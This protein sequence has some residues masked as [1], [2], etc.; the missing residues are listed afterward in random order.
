MQQ[1]ISMITLGVADAA[2]ARRFYEALGWSGDS[3]DGD[4]VIFQAGGMI[5]G[6]WGRDRL[7]VDSGVS[8]PGGWGGVTFAHYVNSVAEVDQ[9]LAAAEDA[10]AT[11]GRA[12]GPTS[13]GGY[14][15]VFLDIDGHPWEIG[16]NPG[17]VVA[18][19]GSFKPR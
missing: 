1:R 19:G 17:W 6:L 7:A 11:I 13:W 12:G 16:Y 9:I 3:P 14:S 2:R 5:V 15:G 4:I 18:P 8:D 10:G